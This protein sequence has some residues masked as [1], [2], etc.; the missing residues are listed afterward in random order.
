LCE[1]YL[2]QFE[3]T[4][5]FQT[6]ALFVL[7]IFYASQLIVYVAATLVNYFIFIDWPKYQQYSTSAIDLF[8]T[9]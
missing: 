7:I 8:A 4:F 1:N 9:E 2:H 5:H 6:R 3:A